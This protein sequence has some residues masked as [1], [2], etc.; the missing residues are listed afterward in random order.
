MK[1]HS[2]SW[3]VAP[4]IVLILVWAG[5]ASSSQVAESLVETGLLVPSSSALIVLPGARGAGFGL[6]SVLIYV[7]IGFVVGS[8]ISLSRKL[9]YVWDDKDMVYAGPEQE[10][11]PEKGSV[12]VED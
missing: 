1:L 7:G 5:A 9:D 10:S 8:L 11:E 3:L 6:A 4:L 12:V 2:V